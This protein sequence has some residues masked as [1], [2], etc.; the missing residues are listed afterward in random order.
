MESNLPG[1]L[2]LNQSNL[3]DFLECPRR[4]ELSVLQKTA[5]PSL[6]SEP[7]SRYEELTDRG[8]KFHQLCNQFFIGVEAGK[9]ASSI[10]DPELKE[11]WE[12]FYPYGSD[13]LNYNPFSEQIL[14]APFQGHILVA[15]YDLVAELPG[16]RLLITD[17]KTS[18]KK[19]SRMD[20]SARAQ[21][22]LYPFILLESFRDLFGISHPIPERITLQYW[23][24]LA[25]DPEEVFTY[26]PAQHEQSGHQ[27]S[28]IIYQ[29]ENLIKSGESFPLSDDPKACKFCFY[30][31]F[32][33]R[34]YTT[35]LSKEP[36]TYEN[37]DLSN[38]H[39]DID[40][41]NEIEF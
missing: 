10:H 14:R 27:L 5:W 15:K 29:I 4:F 21:T 36:E 40:L 8:T 3:Q 2:H 20:L 35:S 24:P 33:E 19:P 32:C 41:I 18:S 38:T 23:Y 7:P 34:D 25:A 16:N 1:P 28:S 31:S 9:I 26:T 6:Y 17:W 37:E 22:L 11:L 39:F 13:L 12:G 30:R